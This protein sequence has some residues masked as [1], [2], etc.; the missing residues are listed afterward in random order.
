M[1]NGLAILLVTDINWKTFVCY[2]IDSFLDTKEVVDLLFLKSS[3][4]I[5]LGGGDPMAFLNFME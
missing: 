5:V 2:Q 4:Y 3:I 1:W